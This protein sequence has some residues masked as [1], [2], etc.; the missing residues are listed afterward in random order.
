MN[1]RKTVWWLLTL[2]AVACVL[3]GC[4]GNLADDAEAYDPAQYSFTLPDTD[5]EQVTLFPDHKTLIAYFTG[6]D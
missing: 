3:V 5:G 4:G 6:V 2:V 1:R